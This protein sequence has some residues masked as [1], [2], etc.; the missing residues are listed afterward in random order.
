M[1][2]IR[3]RQARGLII[4]DEAQS[5]QGRCGSQRARI[6]VTPNKCIFSSALM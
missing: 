2:R 1:L 3:E 4:F 6:Y 5:H